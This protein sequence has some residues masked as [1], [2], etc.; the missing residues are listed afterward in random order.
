[1]K[2][3]VDRSSPS[4]KLR[5]FHQ[6]FKDIRTEIR[7]QKIVLSNFVMAFITGNWSVDA[8]MSSIYVQLH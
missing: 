3:G 1:M 6:W 2:W 4:E 8:V 5:D 7:Y